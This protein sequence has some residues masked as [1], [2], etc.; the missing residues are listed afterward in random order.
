LVSTEKELFATSKNE[1]TRV[2]NK[3]LKRIKLN[4]IVTI[5]IFLILLIVWIFLFMSFKGWINIFN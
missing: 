5:V 3:L 4:N 2:I 1:L